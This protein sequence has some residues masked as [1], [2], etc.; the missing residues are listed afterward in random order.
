MPETAKYLYWWKMRNRKDIAFALRHQ[1][2][3]AASLI[4]AYSFLRPYPLMD[5][6]HSSSFVFSCLLI[7][8]WCGILASVSWEKERLRTHIEEE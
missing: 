7:G 4:I 6:S 8:I 5:S 3:L 2:P 1:L